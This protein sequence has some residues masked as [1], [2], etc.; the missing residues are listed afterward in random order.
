[1]TRFKSIFLIF[2]FYFSVTYCEVYIEPV[3]PPWGYVFD[4]WDGGPIDIINPII[5]YSGCLQRRT[6]VPWFMAR[7]R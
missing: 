7:P 5:C 3:G 6:T 1:M 2:I 4:K